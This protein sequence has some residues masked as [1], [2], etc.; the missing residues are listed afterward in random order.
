MWNNNVVRNELRLGY[1]FI[2]NGIHHT[3]I[4]TYETRFKCRTNEGNTYFI[5]YAYFQNTKHFKSKH[6][7]RY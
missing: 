3:I 2:L 7:I 5:T 4:R 1:T 6:K